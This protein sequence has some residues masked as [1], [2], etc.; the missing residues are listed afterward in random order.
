MKK[1]SIT[2]L[3]SFA[4]VMMLASCGTPAASSVAKSSSAPASSTPASS[5]P[6]TSSS[7]EA[8]TTSI[9]DDQKI[10]ITYE[11]TTGKT[12]QPYLENYIKEFNEKY[13]QYKAVPS[14]FSGSYNELKEDVI[15]GF[16]AGSYPDVVQC[17]PDHVAEYLN[18]G[19]AVDMD[20]F[21]D[22]TDTGIGMSAADKADYIT[23]FMTEGSQYSVSGTYSLPNSKSTELMFWNKD[24]LNGLILNQTGHVINEGRALGQEYFDNL[25]WEELFTNFCPAIVAYNESLAAD[26]KILKTDQAYHSVFA[27][28]SDDNLFITLA[29]QYG[30][31]YTSI[32]PTT[33][34]GSAD[35]NN[36][37]MKG[38]L[39]TFHDAA[40]AGYIISKGS[41]GGNYTNTYFTLQNTLFS[42]G[43]TGGVS[44]QFAAANPMDVGVARIPH[45]A[46][47][48]PKVISQGPSLCVLSHGSD[49]AAKLREQGA[50]LLW[51]TMTT[52]K[53]SVNW[54]LNSG[55]MPIR[56]SS[57]QDATYLASNDED[58][59]DTKTV[60]RLK[61]RSNTYTQQVLDEM[62]SSPVF[63]GSS[64][65]RNA[66][67]ALMVY[68]L[69]KGTYTEADWTD[70]FN[71]QYAAATKDIK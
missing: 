12:T 38:L 49:E 13:P 21:I 67:A 11:N 9:P 32:N 47:K 14:Y 58:T 5:T 64:S 50:Y 31:A 25:T 69:T 3:T 23:A 2:I 8:S 55:Y 26:K 40:N 33:G 34:K 10:V 54:A 59:Y 60:D 68:A 39:K 7:S 37:N 63:L 62:Y 65:C 30:Y 6:S 28:D 51:K 52:T 70:K 36:A 43:S 1:N 57:Y 66:A 71:T 18:Y 42:V 29:E 24:V 46:G 53:N 56:T 61:A 4:A 45:A 20:Q 27:Y 15:K 19:K 41:A 44:Y 35:F 48:D 22:S 16:S 17:Y